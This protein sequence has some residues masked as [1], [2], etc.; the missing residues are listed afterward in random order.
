[1]EDDFRITVF[2][3]SKLMLKLL[4][5]EILMVYINGFLLNLSTLNCTINLIVFKH[6][7][8]LITLTIMCRYNLPKKI[9]GTLG[10]NGSE[11]PLS[12]VG[13]NISLVPCP[14]GNSLG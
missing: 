3:T 4:L 10:V 8:V 2:T 7:T 5:R 6:K 9:Y 14:N 11:A 12:S 13:P 1:M